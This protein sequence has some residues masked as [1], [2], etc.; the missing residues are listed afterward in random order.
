MARKSV[1]AVD[2]ELQAH[3]RECEVRYQS[4]LTQLEKFEK[5]LFR[6]EGLILA[7]TVTVLGS[8]ASLFV[9]YLS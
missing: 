2:S 4:I 3:E 1:Q 6:M 9:L 5:R 8:A 7:S